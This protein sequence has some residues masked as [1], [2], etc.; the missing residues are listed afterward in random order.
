MTIPS[1]SPIVPQNWRDERGCQGT[2]LSWLSLSHPGFKGTKPGAS[3][4]CAREDNTY[5]NKVHRD[6]CHKYHKYT[7]YIAEVLQK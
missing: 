5:N 3:H 1:L 4:I 2:S 7:Y 6:K